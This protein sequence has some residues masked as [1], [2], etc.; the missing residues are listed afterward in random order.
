MLTA[1]DQA[2]ITAA[3]SAGADM[4]GDVK[5]FAHSLILH[6][7]NDASGA[8]PAVA[9]DAADHFFEFIPASERGFVQGI[10]GSFATGEL[11]AIESDLKTKATA[12]AGAA[13]NRIDAAIGT[14]AAK[15]A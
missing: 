10:V 9:K 2:V 13:L 7:A 11:T 14:V 15:L 4:L 8:V 3:K 5:T 6:L 1:D 12:L